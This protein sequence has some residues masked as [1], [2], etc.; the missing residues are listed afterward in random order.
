LT[1]EERQRRIDE[2]LC[3]YCGEPGHIATS[4]PKST[5]K[6]A[7]SDGNKNFSGKG[8]SATIEDVPDETE[9]QSPV[10]SENE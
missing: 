9:E 10:Q 4:C 3:L 1:P 2:N 7:I 8:R 6:A 5:S